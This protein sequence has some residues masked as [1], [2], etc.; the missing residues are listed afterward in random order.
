M[1]LEKHYISVPVPD[2]ERVRKLLSD[3]GLLDGEYKIISE[4]GMLYIPIVTDI[5]LEAIH[6]Q[7][8]DVQLEIGTRHFEAT[9]QGPRTLA[10]ALE[11]E[12]TPDELML[13]PRAYDLIGDIAVLEIPDELE[14]YS[15]LIG[16]AFHRMHR[17]FKTVLAKRGAVSGVTRVRGYELLSGDDRTKTI[18]TEY[19]CRLAVDLEKAYFSPRLL[20]EHNRIAQ[21]VEDNE[22]V[23]D[24]FCG[25]GPFAIHI[26]RQKRA[27]I[28]AIDVNP[29]AIEL[30]KESIT[31]NK[32]VGEIVPVVADA[33][34][35][36]KDEE[37][38]A[39]RVIMNHPSGASDFIPDAC[40]ILKPGGTIHYYDFISGDS[41]ETVMTWKIQ[42]LIEEAGH[43]VRQ[44]SLVRRVRDSAPY[45]Y[46]MVADILIEE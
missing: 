35:Y 2:G 34:D 8:K 32:L 5:A 23:V 28:I 27:R 17:N 25:V 29:S 7:I 43:S 22:I 11:G 40:R 9:A 45:E 12:L 24:M 42:Q 30:L 3:I 21:L 36:V 33:H 14:Q 15:K 13:L 4:D 31:L 10:E 37:V 26:A 44:V 39:N 18:H 38:S 20:E 41:P 6:K 16:S 1:S 19:G 46:Q